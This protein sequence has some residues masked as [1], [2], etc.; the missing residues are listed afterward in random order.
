MVSGRVGLKAHVSA[1]RLE[2]ELINHLSRSHLIWGGSS[3]YGRHRT[4]GWTGGEH[5]PSCC[6][7]RVKRRVC[8]A[9]KK[10]GMQH[11]A[12]QA[13][14]PVSGMGL[15]PALMVL[16]CASLQSKALHLLP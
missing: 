13:G 12:R 7:Q 8:G 9:D 10:E 6:R 5:S 14:F 4:P 15:Q 3:G 1:G 16:G 2:S 11:G